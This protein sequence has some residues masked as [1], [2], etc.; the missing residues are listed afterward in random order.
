M[1]LSPLFLAILLFPAAVSAAPFP[2]MSDTHPATPAVQWLKDHNVIQGNPDGTFR[3]Q[4]NLNRAELAKIL[5][6][7]SGT[8]TMVK[9]KCFTDVPT[10]AWYA[11]YVCTAKSLGIV[12]GYPDGTFRAANDVTAVEAAKMIAATAKATLSGNGAKDPWYGPAMRYLDERHA[13]PETVYFL[14]DKVNRGETA[15]MMQGV[16]ATTTAPATTYAALQSHM[17]PR[18]GDNI[19]QRGEM[20]GHYGYQI[21]NGFEPGPHYCKRDCTAQ[22]SICGRNGAMIAPDY[23]CETDA[24][25]VLA[26]DNR[27]V[28]FDAMRQSNNADFSRDTYCGIHT[29]DMDDCPTCGRA[30]VATKAVCYQNQCKT[31][32]ELR[33]QA[34]TEA[35]MRALRESMAN[36]VC[37][38][39]DI[40]CV[41][42]GDSTICEKLRS[43]CTLDDLRSQADIQSCAS[44]G[45]IVTSTDTSVTCFSSPPYCQTNA[46]CESGTVCMFTH[47]DV[48]YCKTMSE[49]PCAT[50]DPSRDAYIECE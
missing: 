47:A 26:P 9:G 6:G 5:V 23:R 50:P 33:I 21:K 16:F 15:I 1:R 11:S 46:Q 24:D 20:D 36:G 45:G 28:T 40:R 43:D 48:G 31:D 38:A 17:T 41:P 32:A 12:E 42:N 35:N 34:E 25:C 19:C 39:S 7:A 8:Q 4:S 44:K 49:Q 3:P 27:A 13:L 22:E 29:F 37:E 10:D 30:P 18:C 2:D 14:D